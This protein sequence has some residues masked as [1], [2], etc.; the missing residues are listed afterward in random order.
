MPSRVKL[1]RLFAAALAVAL[2]GAAP[3]PTVYT[4]PA[5]LRN[6]GAPHADNPYDV[7]LPDGRIVAPIGSS[8]HVGGRDA[9]GVALSPDGRYAIVTNGPA[10]SSL[11]VV[12]TRTMARSSEYAATGTQFFL[13]VAALKDPANPQQ[14]LVLASTGNGNS[15]EFFRMDGTGTL[16]PE[17]EVAMPLANDPRFINNGGAFPGSIVLASN[18]RIAY[19]VNNFADS[20]TAV[21]L[22]SRTVLHSATVGYFPYDAGVSGRNLYVTDPG[23]MLYGKNVQPSRAPVFGN[24]PFAPMQASAFTDVSLG[25]NGDVQSAISSTPM[26]QAPDGV[27]NV[28]GAHPSAMVISKDGRYAYVCM[29]N[30][31]RVAVVSLSGAPRVVSGLQ[32]RLFDKSP[33]GTQPD[34]IVR[35]PDGKRLYVALAGMNAIAV[36]DARNPVKLHRLGLIPTGWYP[37]A[38]AVSRTGRYLYVANAKGDGAQ[39]TLQ[40]IDLHK[41]PLQ[42][43]TLSAL[44]YLRVAH[45]AVANSIVPPLRSLQRSSAIRH[46]VFIGTGE[47]INDTSSPTANLRTLAAQFAYAGNFYTEAPDPLAAHQIAASGQSTVYTEKTLRPESP[48]DYPRSGYIFNAAA[49]ANETYR[50]YGGLMRLWGYAAGLYTFN[51]PALAAL[52]GRAD[53]D[54]PAAGANV[55]DLA[56]AKEFIADYTRL[57]QQ[58]A[59]PDFTYVDLPGGPD[60]QND[61]ALGAVVDFLTHQPSWSSTAIFI[62]P[63][64]GRSGAMDTRAYAVVVS[65]YAKHHYTGGALLSTPGILKT[66]EELLGL[67]PLSLGDLL[68]T[69]MSGFFT[70]TPDV[71]PFTAAAAPASAAPAH[72]EQR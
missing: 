3:L 30:V 58:N 59:V 7:V 34:A 23:L 70:E 26:D 43:T 28:G 31:D 25:P 39:S 12:D 69:D 18:H 19:V 49:R 16:Q 36:L 65:P 20:V 22:R 5:G 4:A 66:E 24:V 48:D 64:E 32:L 15:V 55:T 33:Y 2:T 40:R 11:A 37:S 68:A 62:A 50:D 21:D 63:N 8:V 42:R 71:T 60:S 57:E 51:V 14:T 1:Q 27:N 38:I 47:D 67:A 45:R 54:Y 53:V 9:I 41:L 46:V 44:R 61:A 35:S 56:R 52:S 10:A 6:A 29:A 17:N 13:G 72:V